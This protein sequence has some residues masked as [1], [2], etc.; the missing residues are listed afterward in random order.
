MHLHIHTYILVF[1]FGF[2]FETTYFCP[3][4]SSCQIQFTFHPRRESPV[5]CRLLVSHSMGSAVVTLTGW[6]GKPSIEIVDRH[7]NPVPSIESYMDG[8]NATQQ[9]VLQGATDVCVASWHYISFVKNQL[10]LVVVVC[11]SRVL[12]F[13]A[14][15]SLPLIPEQNSAPSHPKAREH[16]NFRHE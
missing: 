14:N 12:N 2:S 5:S 1:R 10:V 11:S 6:G 16:A 15:R 9:F 7:L 8:F 13:I 3:A 4:R